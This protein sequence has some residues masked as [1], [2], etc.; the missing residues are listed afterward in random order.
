MF[1][2]A[3]N[4]V[5]AE[6]QVDLTNPSCEDSSDEVQF[7]GEQLG[8]ASEVVVENSRFREDRQFWRWA[9]SNCAVAT[10]ATLHYITWI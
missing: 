7:V 1:T 6:D 2:A 10:Y 9:N 3:V 8:N 4:N 5:N